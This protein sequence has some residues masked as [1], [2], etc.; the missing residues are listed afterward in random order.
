MR[1]NKETTEKQGAKTPKKSKVKGNVLAANCPS[2]KI[3]NNLT[4]KWSVLV[5]L[6]LANGEVKR[7]SEIRNSIEGIS[8]KMLTQTLK[9][10]EQD[11]LVLRKSYNVVPPYVEYSL[12]EIGLEAAKNIIGIVGW[13]E[14]NLSKILR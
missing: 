6:V 9:A 14:N 7:F 13:I 11:Q 8:E 4:S 3:L 1:K 2:R 10:L 12:T 5:F